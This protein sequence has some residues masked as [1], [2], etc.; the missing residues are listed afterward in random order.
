MDGTSREKA[1]KIADDWGL[2]A[3]QKQQLLDQPD[4]APQIV[5]IHDA[6][7]RLFELDEVRANA[8]VKRRNRAF[9]GRSA[10]D[11]MLAGE[12]ERVR[13]YSMYQIYNGGY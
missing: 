10:L 1:D 12:I 3:E 5:T 4:A 6:L 11:T 13:K 8:F 9:G 7:F 2:T